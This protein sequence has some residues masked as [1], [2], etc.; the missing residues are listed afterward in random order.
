MELIHFQVFS[1]ESH[2]LKQIEAWSSCV[3]SASFSAFEH[4]FAS[5]SQSGGLDEGW[6]LQKTL[7]VAP[8]LFLL[9]CSLEPLLSSCF[10]EEGE[11]P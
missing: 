4:S 2:N 3:E 5:N 6:C 8:Q 7:H 1:C 10:S 9:L 11:E